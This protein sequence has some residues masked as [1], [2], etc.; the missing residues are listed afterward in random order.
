[1]SKC[2]STRAVGGGTMIKDFW[3]KMG[4]CL[5][6]EWLEV[7]PKFDENPKNYGCENYAGMPLEFFRRQKKCISYTYGE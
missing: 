1:M 3:D 4:L 5:S 2:R 6:C 7:Y